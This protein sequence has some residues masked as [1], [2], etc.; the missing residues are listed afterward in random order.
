VSER[1]Y[2]PG[3]FANR[4]PRPGESLN[5]FLLR[6]SEVNAYRGIGDVLSSLLLRD[7]P[8]TP[9]TL[10]R[11]CLQ[12]RTDKAMLGQIGRAAAGD[13]H[14]LDH[15]AALSLHDEAIFA[16]SCRIDLDAL[17]LTQ[18]QVCPKCLS[19]LGIALEEW[20]LAPVTCCPTHRVYL[21]AACTRCETPLDWL[22]PSLFAC[23]KCGA[24]LRT[25]EVMAAPAE[26]CV[27][28][29]DFAALAPFRVRLEDGSRAA[30]S[31]DTTFRI[32]KSLSLELSHFYQGIF[33]EGRYFSL[34]DLARRHE[35]VRVL[36]QARHGD[37][38]DLWRLRSHFQRQLACLDVLPERRLA[39]RA[40]FRVLFSGAGLPREFASSMSASAER[41]AKPSAAQLF[42]GRP[43][44]LVTR[45]HVQAFL[46][47][48]DATLLALFRL[49]LLHE[50]AWGLAFDF[51]QVLGAQ[52]YLADNLLSLLDIEQFVG[53]P[54][55]WEDLRN[56]TLLPR[57]N[58]ISSLDFRVDV[59]VFSRIQL[60]LM[61]RVQGTTNPR[62]PLTLGA[63]VARAHRP[64]EALCAL[65]NE[66]LCGTLARASWASPF[67]WASLVCE[68]DAIEHIHLQRR[69]VFGS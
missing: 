37:A 29:E 31:W 7:R 58:P 8:G 62:S 36:G 24:D 40:A 26:E 27:V 3:C 69:E 67:T 10:A 42:K 60:Q 57:W 22:R 4:L 12:V 25:L 59:G 64:F 49:G 63:A 41:V 51:D 20:D 21:V 39:M 68:S 2:L 47:V 1:D 33:P 53:V 11:L 61:E 38:Y 35:C 48:D 46:G 54:L 17:M 14:C 52:G 30:A 44:S 9:Q 56:S 6:L 65:V 5:G 28:S 50:P 32:L 15:Y 18:A 16:H 34:L 19:E 45:S 66:L 23:A 13:A 55:D 43:R